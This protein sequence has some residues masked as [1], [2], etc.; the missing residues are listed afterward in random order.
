MIIKKVLD[1]NQKT[2]NDEDCSEIHRQNQ[3]R[4]EF[5]EV[6]RMIYN[7]RIGATPAKN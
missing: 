3:K 7:I 1:D 4:L 5:F 6:F 2:L